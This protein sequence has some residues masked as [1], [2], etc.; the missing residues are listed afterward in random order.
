MQTKFEQ[1]RK[2]N[3]TVMARGQQKQKLI[4]K[5]CSYIGTVMARFLLL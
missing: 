5:D 3:F 1:I 4:H 2:Q